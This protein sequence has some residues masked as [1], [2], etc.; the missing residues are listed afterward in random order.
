M[1]NELNGNRFC[2]LTKREK[3]FTREKDVS[4]FDSIC[5]S[6]LNYMNNPTPLDRS[7][8]NTGLER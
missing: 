2:L 7:E 6:F 4:A 1:N 5:T 3:E 8:I